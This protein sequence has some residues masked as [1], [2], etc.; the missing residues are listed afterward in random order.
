M[1]AAVDTAAIGTGAVT[2]Q[3]LTISN[4]NPGNT[5]GN[6]A[7]VLAGR[8]SNGG[9]DATPTIT[10]SVDGATGWTA[11]ALG[12]I[13]AYSFNF[14]VRAF[15]KAG[16]SGNRNVL[17][18]GNSSIYSNQAVV[19]RA[20]GLDTTTPVGGIWQT[21][22]DIGDGAETGTLNAAP[23]AQDITIAATCH[24]CG[25]HPSTTWGTGFAE[26]GADWSRTAGATGGGPLRIAL[27]GTGSTST[28]VPITDAFVPGGTRFAGVA[29]GFVLRGAA[30][31]GNLDLRVNDAG[32]W[33]DVLEF[34]VND[35][36]TWRPA[37][38]VH[39]RVSGSWVRLW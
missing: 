34:H 3:T 15:I 26:P 11:I 22:A 38:E 20:T 36:G 25:S 2:T 19:F 28:S 29:I 16:W 39:K 30:A 4:V 7:I 21:S 6:Y 18:S 33:R 27:R 23:R 24:D 37:L 12:R 13:P 5:A 14:A 8:M 32:T 35:A 17:V 31:G 9:N 1:V 10:D